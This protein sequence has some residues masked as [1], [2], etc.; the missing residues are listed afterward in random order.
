MEELANVEVRF[1]LRH[2]HPFGCPAY[3]LMTHKRTP[4]KW[5]KRAKV[6]IY[7]GTL[8]NTLGQYT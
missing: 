5:D 3:V 4:S 8:K 7:I 2:F 1:K 6:G